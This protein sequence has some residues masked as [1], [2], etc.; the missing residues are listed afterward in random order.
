MKN[1]NT[2]TPANQKLTPIF[3]TEDAFVSYDHF[4]C[5]DLER[6]PVYFMNQGRRLFVC[7]MPHEYKT[8]DDDRGGWYD[9]RLKEGRQDVENYFSQLNANGGKYFK[10]YI[11]NHK[12]KTLPEFL[13]WIKANGYT[14]DKNMTDFSI[15]KDYIDFSGNLNEYSAAFCFRI[16]DKALATHLMNTIDAPRRDYTK[17]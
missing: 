16:Y 5:G 11:V 10:F 15:E 6:V 9:A 12:D 4:N 17:E 2:I 8:R 1:T 7:N 14:F 13:E 3:A